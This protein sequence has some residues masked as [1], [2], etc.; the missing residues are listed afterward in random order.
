MEDLK[1]IG[2]YNEEALDVV[3]RS[4]DTIAIEIN[5]IKSYLQKSTYDG[6]IEIGRKLKEAKELVSHGEWGEWLRVKV[7]FS[8]RSASKYMQIFDA[9]AAGQITIPGTDSNSPAYSNLG[10]SKLL[11]LAVLEEEKREEFVKEVDVANLST[12]ELEKKI[13]DL[14]EEKDKMESYALDLTKAEKEMNDKI[15]QQEA[16]HKEAENKIKRLEAQ[17]ADIENI[18]EDEDEEEDEAFDEEELKK[19]VDAATQENKTEIIQLKEEIRKAEQEAIDIKT[20]LHSLELKQ[21][22]IIK[23]AKEEAKNNANKETEEEL[24]KLKKAAEEATEKLKDAE[25]KAGLAGDQNI[26][27][28]KFLIDE[29]QKDYHAATG[30][31]SGMVEKDHQ[32]KMKTAL[33]ALLEDLAN[34]LEV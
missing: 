29:L 30:V 4:E 25:R 28:F 19:R 1:E 32:A 17:I 7:D 8:Q 22:D 6:I 21:E 16:A 33:K 26:Q 20:E 9:F 13:K 3:A 23:K 10:F 27:R 2:R 12:R 31:I 18:Q 34:K 11:T 15:A 24:T 5:T 14:Q